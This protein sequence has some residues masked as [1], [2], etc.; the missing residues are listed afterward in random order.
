MCHS[1]GTSRD[2]TVV[3]I[4]AHAGVEQHEVAILNIAAVRHVVRDG[5]VR[6]AANDDAGVVFFLADVTIARAARADSVL[7]DRFANR[8]IHARFERAHDFDVRLRLDGEGFAQQFDFL[9]VFDKTHRMNVVGDIF[10][11]KPGVAL[12]DGVDVGQ[13]GGKLLVERL[14]AGDVD[15]RSWLSINMRGRTKS[16]S[17]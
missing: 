17:E 15:P 1:P 10:D 6:A 12:A 7:V 13:V 16:S 9:L 2:V 14:P 3:A 11:L 5:A 8:L 4:Y